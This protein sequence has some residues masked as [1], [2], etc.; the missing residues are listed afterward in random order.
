MNWNSFVFQ[1]MIQFLLC[2]KILGKIYS[3]FTACLFVESHTHII[4]CH[5]HVH[6]CPFPCV[7]QGLSGQGYIHFFL[8]LVQ[9]SNS[10][11]PK[12]RRRKKHPD[13]VGMTWLC[14]NELQLSYQGSTFVTYHVNPPSSPSHYHPKWVKLQS[15]PV[16]ALI[17]NT[18]LILN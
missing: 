9:P 5:T 4:E 14:N 7:L 16:L 11:R 2:C 15:H 6:T 8:V 3:R 17:T 18:E 1:N 12:E 10:K 13:W